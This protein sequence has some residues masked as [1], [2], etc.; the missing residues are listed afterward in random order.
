MTRTHQD[1]SLSKPEGTGYS[2]VLHQWQPRR[3]RSRLRTLPG[4]SWPVYICMYAS[5]PIFAHPRPGTAGTAVFLI[6]LRAM[7]YYYGIA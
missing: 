3:P 4:I 2:C 1:T 7:L 6:F 5:P